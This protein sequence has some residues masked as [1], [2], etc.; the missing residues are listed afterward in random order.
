VAKVG[1]PKAGG[2][3]SQQATVH[4]WLAADAQGNKQTN[5]LIMPHFKKPRDKCRK[6]LVLPV[7]WLRLQ[8]LSS[9]IKECRFSAEEV[10]S[11]ANSMK[12]SMV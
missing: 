3:I 5:K 1:T 9:R 8:S 11:A 2:T 12:M 10:R 6:L 4:P 7:P